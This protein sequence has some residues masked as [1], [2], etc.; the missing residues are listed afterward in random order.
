[1]QEEG[2]RSTYLDIPEAPF[3]YVFAAL[4]GVAALVA[5]GRLYR[6]LSGRD[7]AEPPDAE[8]AGPE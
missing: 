7:D 3:T 6:L 8:T 1:M 5:F 4:S 2:T